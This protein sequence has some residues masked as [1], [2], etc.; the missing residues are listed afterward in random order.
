MEVGFFG[1]SVEITI[2]GDYFFFWKQECTTKQAKL[3]IKQS[4]S[5]Q[6]TDTAELLMKGA[7]QWYQSFR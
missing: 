4:K 1:Y 5:Q 7:V 3:S 2:G 6:N